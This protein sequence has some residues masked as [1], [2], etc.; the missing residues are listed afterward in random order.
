MIYGPQAVKWL[1]S[2]SHFVVVLSLVV[3]SRTSVALAKSTWEKMFQDEDHDSW[4][5]S[6][7][8]VTDN[9][10]FVGGKGFVAMTRNGHTTKEQ[11]PKKAILGLGGDRIDALFALGSDQSILRFD[12]SR[13]IQE[14]EGHLSAKAK[15]ADK[16]TDDLHSVKY[17]DGAP[18][19]QLVAFGPV[20]ILVRQADGNWIAPPEPQRGQLLSLASSGRRSALPAGCELEGW[21]GKGQGWF[22]CHDRRSFL[23][24]GDKVTTLGRMPS[25]CYFNVSATAFG[26]GEVYASCAHK[27]LWK[28]GGQ[29]WRSISAPADIRSIAITPHC[30]FVATMH[31]VWR[32]CSEHEP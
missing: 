7:W 29:G 26:N 27:G 8:A 31:T 21:L 17:F 6:V 5:S 28:S 3:R 18:D 10:W 2:L 9:E 1:L 4:V 20:S 16:F 11:D 25:G 22:A 32:S 14:H 24:T 19:A 30:S 12:G 13:W 15:K 23:A